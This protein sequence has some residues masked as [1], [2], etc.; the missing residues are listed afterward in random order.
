MGFGGVIRD[1]VGRWLGGFAI[2]EIGGDPLR[3][4]L[5]A[6]KEGLSFCWNFGY[7]HVV[8]EAD[9]IGAISTIKCAI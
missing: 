3:A 1:S 5:L 9:F 6:I 7:K 2:S 8:C 4:E